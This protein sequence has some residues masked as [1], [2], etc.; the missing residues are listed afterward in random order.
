MKIEVEQVG[1]LLYYY[2]EDGTMQIVL[3]PFT[4]DVKSFDFTE[5]NIQKAYTFINK[6]KSSYGR[7]LRSKEAQEFIEGV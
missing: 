6:V 4:G 3:N 7:F 5:I 2:T 1:S